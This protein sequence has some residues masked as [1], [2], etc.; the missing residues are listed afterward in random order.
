[1]PKAYGYMG[2]DFSDLVKMKKERNEKEP[3]EEMTLADKISRQ[4]KQIGWH[5]LLKK[6]PKKEVY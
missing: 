6:D 1:M 4:A 2:P 5:N 3:E